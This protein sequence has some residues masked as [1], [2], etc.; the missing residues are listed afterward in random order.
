VTDRQPKLRSPELKEHGI[1]ARRRSPSPDEVKRAVELYE[2]SL[3]MRTIAEHLGFGE[4]T[5][6]RALVKAG[7]AI[8]PKF[9]RVAQAALCS[10]ARMSRATPDREP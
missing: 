8:R 3:S 6:S 5:I 9:R 10:A 7:V 4:S 1:T 2:G